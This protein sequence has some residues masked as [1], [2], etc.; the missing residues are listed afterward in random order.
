[1]YDLNFVYFCIGRVTFFGH[2]TWM[3][4]RR[5]VHDKIYLH[6]LRRT[7]S[8]VHVTKENGQYVWNFKGRPNSF[9]KITGNLALKSF[10]IGCFL[11]KERSPE[12]SIIW[13]WEGSYGAYGT[14]LFINRANHVV[15]NLFDRSHRNLWKQTRTG[16]PIKKWTFVGASY[17]HRTGNLVLW[18][19]GHTITHHVGKRKID[20]TGAFYIGIF[21][22]SPAWKNPLRG[23]L[24]GLTI[25]DGP[26]TQKQVGSFKHLT[27]KYL[28][29]K[30]SLK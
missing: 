19:D 5:G 25:L 3:L 17:N 27:L 14:H 13:A 7:I 6:G 4:L 11:W 29:G 8:N 1:M 15:A 28:K 23:K 2:K 26:I 21:G 16:M 9:V 12:T 30:S 20:S 22:K 18:E 10:T 24:R